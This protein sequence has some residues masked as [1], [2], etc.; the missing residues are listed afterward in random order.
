[1]TETVN[2]NN[3]NNTVDNSSC[4]STNDSTSSSD[5]DNEDNNEMSPLVGSRQSICTPSKG[6]SHKE[7]L[8]HTQANVIC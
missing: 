2:S 1:M 6:K 7:S 4:D 5:N 8:N 3:H